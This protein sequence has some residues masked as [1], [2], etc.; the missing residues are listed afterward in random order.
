MGGTLSTNNLV[1]VTAFHNALRH[2]TLFVLALLALALVAR[3]WRSPNLVS[4]SGRDTSAPL[5]A[6]P[7]ARRLLRISF[8]LLWILD[9][10]L[11]TQQ[12]M[13]L[14][15]PTEVVAPASSGSP[16][17]VQHLVNDGLGIWTRHPIPAATSAVWIQIGI[18]ALLLLAPRGRLSRSAG[19]ISAG[20]GLLVW[21]FGEAFGGIF[22]P[23]LSW[24]FGAPGAA[25]FYVVAGLLVALPD[26]AWDGRRLGRGIL[27]A[28]GT[29]LLGMGIL[30]AW[31][32]RGFWQGQA[33]PHA[34]PGGLR[35]MTE[36]M[37]S[38]AQPSALSSLISSFSTF[39]A[40]HGWAVNL[41]VVLSLIAV[42]AALLLGLLSGRQK[43]VSAGAGYGVVFS[44]VV[45]VLVQ[46]LGFLGGVGTDP[47]SMIPFALVLVAGWIAAV[48]MTV[49]VPVRVPA[50]STTRAL[51]M[52]VRLQTALGIA[53][54]LGSVGVLLIGAVPM[55][56]A[57]LN[58]R[59]DAIVSQGIN[60]QAESEDAP[61]PPFHLIDQQGKA[62]SLATFR[63]KTVALT[64]LDPVC[65]SDCPL[66]AQEFRQ[67][68]S[69][70]G[71]SP[72]TAFVA[73]VSNPIYR[74]RAF[75]E[76]FDAQEHLNS[77]PNWYFL[78]G[79]TT[80]LTKAWKDYGIEVQTLSGGGMIAHSDVAYV[81][82]RTGAIREVFGSDP[83]G[84][85]AAA[86]SLS[87][88]LDQEMH[89]VMG[90]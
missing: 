75:V 24:L 62:V 58:P 4:P 55:A 45:W 79:S 89:T 21:V 72:D 68:D 76:A 29:F 41:F 69:R 23:G 53:A 13:P 57:S 87:S 40:H 73:V 27:L 2:Q 33:G 85:G 83:G 64:F 54:T 31:P 67:V 6:E 43:V 8:G 35:A 1:V 34:T 84:G 48:R 78:T 51:A 70:L 52:P 5:V 77:V 59:T 9:G 66:I 10:L 11:Q 86:A 7:T 44:L 18:G 12:S 81:I 46:D 15:L 26:P 32:G 30:Q 50:P 22:G 37:S 17:W 16:G 3:I 25:L 61:A 74:S 14:G 80:Q 38:T 47:N 20:W 19:V 88:V 71:T 56:S 60:G 82:D 36:S 42:G 90:T 28:V 65:T 49:P 63:G 39:D